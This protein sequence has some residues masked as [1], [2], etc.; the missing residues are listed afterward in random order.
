MDKLTANLTDEIELN[1]L[2][3]NRLN[4][5]AVG[6]TKLRDLNANTLELLA[7]VPQVAKERV[8]TGNVKL[9]KQVKTQ[10][11]NVPVTLTQEILVIEHQAQPQ[12][13]QQ[14]ELVKVIHDNPAL[15]ST[16]TIDGKPVTLDDNPIEIV[17]SQQIAKV[18]IETQ[19]TENVKVVTTTQTYEETIPVTLRHEELVTEEV[20]LDDPRVISSSVVDTNNNLK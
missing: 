16:I 8:V 5:A 20:K 1:N 2:R 10:T 6:D 19:V 9:S 12:S 4:T 7:E 3:D 14:D 13:L 17:L 18:A 11:I 15:V